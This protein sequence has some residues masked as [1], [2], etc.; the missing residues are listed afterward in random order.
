[1]GNCLKTPFKINARG[2]SI[3]ESMAA[4]AVFSIAAMAV[5]PVYQLAKRQ[6]KLGDSKQLCQNIVRSKLDQYRFGRVTDLAQV[7][8][9]TGEYAG[10]TANPAL[11]NLSI[12]SRSA[13]SAQVGGGGGT[14]SGGFMYAKARYNRF[15]PASCSGNSAAQLLV[16]NA[17]ATSQGLTARLGMRECIGAGAGGAP[18]RVF[19]TDSTTQLCTENEDSRVAAEIPG[20]KLYVRLELETPWKFSAPGWTQTGDA[21]FDDRCPDMGTAAGMGPLYDFN[22]SGDS[23]RVTVTGIMDVEAAGIARF[24]EMDPRLNPQQFVCTAS[25]IVQPEQPALVRYYQSNDGRI[26]GIQG[27]GN[28]GA[29][30]SNLAYTNLYVQQA[31][32]GLRA[33]GITSFSVHPRNLSVY[34]LKPG[35]LTRFSNCSGQPVNCSLTVAANGF[36]DTGQPGWPAVQEFKVPASIRFIGIDYASG[37]VYGMSAEK[38]SLIEIGWSASP[39]RIRDCGNQCTLGSA[40]QPIWANSVNMAQFFTGGVVPAGRL[41]GFFLSPSGDSGYIS[42]YSSSQQFGSTSYTSTIYLSTDASLSAP[43]AKLPVSALS[44]SK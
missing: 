7:A 41:T 23:I 24:G 26:Y 11:L 2:A 15:F 38:T 39:Q 36:S 14:S 44:F 10:L 22:G 17:A 21:R 33:S 28:N 40:P 12:P 43:I 42:D 19:T 31:G 18:P 27:N 35:S 1:M 13:T 37:R 25:A 32:G 29:V 30:D 3:I 5:F 9:G 6:T 16:A 4:F 8:G 20:F 34:L